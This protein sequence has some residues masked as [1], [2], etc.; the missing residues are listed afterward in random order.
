MT[1]MDSDDCPK[2]HYGGQISFFSVTS[3]VISVASIQIQTSC[4]SEHEL[5][6]CTEYLSR[7]CVCVSFS[8]HMYFQV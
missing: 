4:L 1:S 7:V 2:K 8:V 3:S 6:V 5:Q